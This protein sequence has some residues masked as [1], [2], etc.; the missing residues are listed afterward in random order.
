MDLALSESQQLLKNTVRAFMDRETPKDVLVAL[1]MSPTG[2][3]PLTWESAA[4]LGWLG[5]LIPEEYGGS[6]A[7]LTDAAVLF[8]ELGRGPMPGPFFSSGVLGALTILEAATDEQKRR[9][10]PGVANGSTILT[11]ALTEPNA[12]FGPRGVSLAAQRQGDRLV[13]NGVKLFVPDAVAATHL[14]VVVRTGE[15]SE[16]LSL[17]LVDTSL[18]GVR[19]R[20]LPGFI[21]WQCE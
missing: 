8:E 5:M 9:I 13:L 7:S 16:D 3:D 15:G 6:D 17:L 10:L 2:Y 1:Q 18:P 14:I 21:G 12:S 19:A 20:L 11:L 4:G